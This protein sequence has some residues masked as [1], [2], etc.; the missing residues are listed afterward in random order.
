MSK[1]FRIVTCAFI[2]ML[3]AT[4]WSEVFFSEDFETGNNPFSFDVYN[5]F[6]TNAAQWF[7][8]ELVNE[9]GERGRVWKSTFRHFCNDS[10]FGHDVQQKSNWNITNRIHWRTYV[11]FGTTDNSP[12]WQ[13]S[14][15]VSGCS[16][17]TSQRGYELKFPDIG[18]GSGL[19]LGRIIGK[20]RSADGSGRYG[21]FRLYTPDG[22][23]H[24]HDS[25][26]SPRFI[27]NRWYAVEFMVEDN[28]NNDTVK[29]WINNNNENNPDYSFTGGNMFNSSQWSTGMAYNHGYRN[30]DVPYDTDF[31][32]DDVVISNTFIGLAG[33][34]ASPPSAPPNL[35]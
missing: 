26:G 12:E 15:P 8:S 25:Q 2:F 17:I 14:A 5:D 16:G 1:V 13:T 4:S 31:F 7:S 9:G 34:G 3:P 6:Q 33:N 35:Q 22:T 18:G 32:Y 21:R 11:K 30:H 23:N 19:Q 20:L 28:G 10:Y 29:I 24:D 27:S